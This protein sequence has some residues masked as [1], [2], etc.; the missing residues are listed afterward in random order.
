M[1]ADVV[2]WDAHPL[3]VGAIP[4]QVWIDGIPQLA[5]AAVAQSR[6][7]QTPPNPPA[8]DDEAKE[9]LAYRGLQPLA[10]RRASN[11]AFTGVGAENGT[12]L[13][14]EGRIVASFSGGA[15]AEVSID[16]AG[17]EIARGLITIGSKLGLEEVDF[18]Q[19]MSWT[20]GGVFDPLA[21]AVPPILGDPGAAIRAVDGELIPFATPPADS[22]QVYGSRRAT[23]C[24]SS[25]RSRAFGLG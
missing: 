13:V 11:V 16:L 15:H 7:A 5:A 20:D 12:I 8:W 17:G 6:K 10:P 25:F 2:L 22:I 4:R 14:Q 21:A 23:L 1:D 18:M 3:Q 9:A 24:K 19:E